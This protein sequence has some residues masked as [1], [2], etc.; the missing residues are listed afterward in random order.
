MHRYLLLHGTPGTKAD[1]APLVEAAPPGL[2]IECPDLPDNGRA[3]D[4]TSLD[5]APFDEVVDK[6]LE[7]DPTPTVL[8]GWSFG[9]ML[10]ARALSRPSCKTVVRAVLLAGFVCLADDIADRNL[11]LADELDADRIP[12]AQLLPLARRLYVGDAQLV[13][14]HEAALLRAIRDEHN[15]RL[16]RALR[17]GARLR[18]GAEVVRPFETPTLVLHGTDDLAVPASLSERFLTLGSRVQRVLLDGAPHA[19]QF[20]NTTEVARY[21]FAI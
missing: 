20:T 18:S 11:S 7:G 17:R 13:T 9:A 21:I 8:V 10:A 15:G 3:A 12:R 19:L 5:L 16:A 1:F 14:E 4:E 2:K 6:Y